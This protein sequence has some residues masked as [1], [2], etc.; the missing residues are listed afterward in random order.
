MIYF[1]KYVR[2]DGA[3]RMK[4]ALKRGWTTKYDATHKINSAANLRVAALFL[5]VAIN[6][7]PTNRES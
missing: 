7:D 3:M 1:T 2:R 5:L 4:L 6:G